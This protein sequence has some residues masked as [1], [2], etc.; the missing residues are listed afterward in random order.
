MLAAQSQRQ[1]LALRG[2]NLP[3][4]LRTA[5]IA[6]SSGLIIS[7]CGDHRSQPTDSARV[8]KDSYDHRVLVDS[9]ITR[10]ITLYYVQAEMACSV[11]AEG[12]IV[13]VG[14][15]SQG[16]SAVIDNFCPGMLRLPTVGTGANLDYE[17]VIGLMP[18]L[19]VGGVELEPL[20]HLERL[21]VTTFSSFPRH[22]LDV[23]T[24]IRTIGGLL[25]RPRQAERVAE[26]LDSLYMLVI[27]RTASLS[28][29]ER[30]LVYYARTTPLV[31][32]GGGVN[33]EVIRLIGGRSATSTLP[34]EMASVQVSLEQ[35]YLWN[36]DVIILR[37]RASFTPEDLI[38]QSEWSGIRAVRNHRVYQETYGWTEYRVAAFVGFLEK[39]KWLHPE[40][41]ADVD[42]QSAY[43]SLLRLLQ[44]V[45]AER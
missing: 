26:F 44:E 15:L 27:A 35:L 31:T 32:L 24:Q 30:P 14:R 42:P 3:H 40:L 41:F 2:D 11:G 45:R 37:D 6:A 29:D 10:A 21:G 9:T 20:Q 39:A 22:P 23:L 5:A 43:R 38:A 13:A 19:V 18:D 17:E 34:G 12:S 16:Q 36:P 28:E 25:G 1:Q 33:N 7:G 4:I 8:F